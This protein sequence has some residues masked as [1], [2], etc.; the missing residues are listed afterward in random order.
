MPATQLNYRELATTIADVA[1]TNGVEPIVI[2]SII[3][4]ESGWRN[5]KNAAGYPAYGLMQVVSN[6]ALS[7]RPSGAELTEPKTNLQWGARILADAWKRAGSLE[8]ALYNY[9]GGSAWNKSGGHE[10][11]RSRYWRRFC[12]ALANLGA[13]VPLHQA[14]PRPPRDTGAGIH[15][16]AAAMYPMGDNEGEWIPT[17]AR[18]VAMGITWCK[19]VVYADEGLK[20]AKLLLANGIMPVIRLYREKPYPGT[21]SEKQVRAV[22]EYVKFGCL[23]FERGNEPNNPSQEWSVALNDDDLFEVL[24]RDWLRDARTITELGGFIAVDAMSPGGEWHGGPAGGDDIGFLYRFLRGLKAA[25]ATELLRK[26]GWLAVH[27]AFLNHP[28]DYPYDAVNQAEHKGQ[29]LYQHWDKAGNATGA[30]NCERKWLAAASVFVDVFGFLVPVMTTE[31]GAWV[32]NRADPRYPELTIQSASERNALALR[33]MAQQPTWYM[34]TMPWLWANRR[35]ANKHEAFER[36]AW[37][38]TAGWGNCPASEPSELP[39][40]AMLEQAPCPTR[41]LPSPTPAPSP[42]TP[43]PPIPP[44]SPT[45]TAIRWNAEEAVRELQ[46]GKPDAARSRLLEH[47]IPPL[48]VLEGVKK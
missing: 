47:V 33:G 18:W 31:G 8:K 17:I 15:A 30:S 32:G 44:P 24:I 11:Y 25:G 14:Y 6:E 7:G 40:I 26:R 35:W 19:L 9:S 5:V 12:D 10:V 48:Y 34:A 42:P 4:I 2:A 37:V 3:E 23:W 46:A 36:D 45:I 21:L 13:D 29:H 16:G 28:T 41:N 39:I 38:R 43:S 1:A 27:N 20:P 22:W